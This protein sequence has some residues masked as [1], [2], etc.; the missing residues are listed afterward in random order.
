M[1][2][3]YRRAAVSA[4]LCLRPT[5]E[6]R[7][8]ETEGFLRAPLSLRAEH[9]DSPEEQRDSPEEQRDLRAN[10]HRDSLGY[11]RSDPLGDSLHAEPH[12]PECDVRRRSARIGAQRPRAR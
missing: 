5:Q 9:R 8:R 10:L 4:N 6:L 12:V 7:L 11:P 3:V 2:A 1:P